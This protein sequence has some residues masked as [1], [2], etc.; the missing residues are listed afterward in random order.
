MC[1]R[2]HRDVQ[3]AHG[4]TLEYLCALSCNA[5]DL[6]PRVGWVKMCWCADR[7]GVQMVHRGREG[8]HRGAHW[9][10]VHR[11]AAAA[12]KETYGRHGGANF[13]GNHSSKTQLRQ[14]LS[15]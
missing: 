13:E 15:L 1:I 4:F 11:L 12:Q 2:V 8:L 14:R 5:C 9:L 6:Y 10:G 3:S 7:T